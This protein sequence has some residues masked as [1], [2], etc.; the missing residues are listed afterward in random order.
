MTNIMDKK[1]PLPDVRFC[2]ECGSAMVFKKFIHCYSTLTGA[3]VFRLQWDCSKNRMSF[4][5]KVK[6]YCSDFSCHTS[7]VTSV[8]STKTY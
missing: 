2:A 4:F 6:D 1:E 7:F 5:Q 3:P 8:D